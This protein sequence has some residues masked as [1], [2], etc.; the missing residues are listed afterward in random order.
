MSRPGGNPDFIKHKLTTD[1]PEPLTAKLTVRLPQSMMDK[2]KAVDNYP[3]FVRQCLQDGL[4]KLAK[5]I[6]FSLSQRQKESMDIASIVTELLSNVEKAS[7][8]ILIKEL[9]EKEIIEAGNFTKK[10]FFTFVEAVRTI[11]SKPKIKD[12]KPEELIAKIE[13]IKQETLQPILDNIFIGH[14]DEVIRQKWINLLESAILG[15]P[16]HPRYI[17]ALRLLDGIDANV[18]EF[19]YEFRQRRN[20]LNNYEIKTELQKRKIENVT[21][22]MVKDSL[23]NLVERGLCDVNTLQ[24]KPRY[25]DMN[26]E[27]IYISEFG[28]KFL[29]IVGEKS[30]E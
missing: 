8:G 25:S 24:G 2:L 29:Y 23:S 7:V 1:R 26:S 14:E 21:E 5:V 12:I 10:K 13:D 18:L 28:R 27:N 4:D 17:D 9:F 6:S 16:I 11:Y 3:E 15:Y 20:R 30:S 22:E 19:M